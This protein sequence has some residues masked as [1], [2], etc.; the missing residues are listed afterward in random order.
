MIP[1]NIKPLVGV[2]N[3][4]K[5]LSFFYPDYDGRSRDLTAVVFRYPELADSPASVDSFTA[6]WEFLVLSSYCKGRVTTTP[7]VGLEYTTGIL[8]RLP[9]LNRG[10]IAYEAIALPLS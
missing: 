9:D 8:S 3:I 10:P 1:V 5:M 7:K 6:D 2:V 4:K